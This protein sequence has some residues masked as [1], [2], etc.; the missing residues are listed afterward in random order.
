MSLHRLRAAGV[1]IWLDTLSRDLLEDG[2]L[3]GLIADGVSGVTSNPAIFA[4]AIARSDRYDAPLQAAVSAGVTEPQELFFRLA[5]DDVRR[6]ADLL[7]PVF[8]ASGRR[9]GFV[10]FE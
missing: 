4:K 6:A 8:E 9:D 10:S 7:R 5:L 2:T 1:S 3:A